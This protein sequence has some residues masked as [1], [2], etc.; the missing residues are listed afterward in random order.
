MVEVDEKSLGFSKMSNIKNP[1]GVGV[2]LN[3]YNN[4]EG[5]SKDPP[6]GVS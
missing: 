5:G 1:P 2:V 3:F 6:H 4:K